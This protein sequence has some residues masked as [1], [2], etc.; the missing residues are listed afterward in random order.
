MQHKMNRNN[1]PTMSSN[2]ESSCSNEGSFNLYY[3]DPL[4]SISYRPESFMS[5][6]PTKYSPKSSPPQLC[7]ERKHLKRSLFHS[8]DGTI[9]P[10]FLIPTL[11]DDDDV[12]R[13]PFK[14]RLVQRLTFPAMGDDNTS[15]VETVKSSS[16]SNVFNSKHQSATSCLRRSSSTSSEKSSD[17]AFVFSSGVGPHGRRT[18]MKRRTS[19]TA[20]SA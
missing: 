20:L 1:F 13:K 4:P 5:P 14:L 3:V 9:C 11:D 10:E 17:S 7:R 16:L 2:E 19:A 6:V 15:K 8:S 12:E 18:K